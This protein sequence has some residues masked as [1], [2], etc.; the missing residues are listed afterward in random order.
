MGDR[1]IR[2]ATEE[3]QTGVATQVSASASPSNDATPF[4]ANWKRT[5]VL[6]A[7][8]DPGFPDPRVPPAPLPTPA[9]TPKP[10]PQPKDTP[11][12][13]PRPSAAGSST[14]YPKATSP[15]LLHGPTVTPVPIDTNPK[16]L[17]TPEASP[18]L[19]P[20]NPPPR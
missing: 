20:S 10:T 19:G 2:K 5:Q 3:G 7:A 16:N 9:P 11:T 6:A 14:P 12:P 18:I 1:V 13:Q 4:G 17:P 15:F 8:P